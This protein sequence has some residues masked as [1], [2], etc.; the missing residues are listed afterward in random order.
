MLGL[1]RVFSSSAFLQHFKLFLIRA[2][3]SY[4][5]HSKKKKK[6]GT[7]GK[8]PISSILAPFSLFFLPQ[9]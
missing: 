7:F 2:L 1:L 4:N 8:V 5:S 3:L 6:K 9:Q